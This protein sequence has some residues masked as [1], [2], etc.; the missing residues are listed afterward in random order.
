MLTNA[1][2]AC[3]MERR[4]AYHNKAPV[5]GIFVARHCKSLSFCYLESLA[6]L[7]GTFAKRGS[8]PSAARCAVTS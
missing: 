6:V 5:K 7:P 4:A 8:L 3:S 1:A 2:E